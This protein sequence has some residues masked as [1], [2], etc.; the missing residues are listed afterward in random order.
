LATSLGL[1]K[2]LRTRLLEFRAR[3]R[4]PRARVRLAKTVVPVDRAASLAVVQP[5][6][7]I[8]I[9][10]VDHASVPSRRRK[11]FSSDERGIRRRPGAAGVAGFDGVQLAGS[12]LAVQVSAV[13]N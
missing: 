9:L 3:R 11:Y 1:G 6:R 7:V 12:D 5:E 10:S 8:E 13:R 2:P 4:T